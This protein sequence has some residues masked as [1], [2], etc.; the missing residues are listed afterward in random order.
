MPSDATPRTMKHVSFVQPAVASSETAR[1]I[2]RSIVLNF[3]RK[4]QPVSRAEV[5]RLSGLQRNT[6]SLI[7]E[8]LIAE[9]WVVEGAVGRLPR[10]RRPTFLELDG[11]RCAICVDLRPTRVQLGVGHLNGAFALSDQF[12]TP[13]TPERAT[14]ELVKRIRALIRSHPELTY[15]GIGITV[16]GRVDLQTQR[17]AFAPNLGWPPTDLKTPLERATGLTV[18]LE[19]AANACALA[20]LWFHPSDHP[21]DIIALTVSEGI[22][23]GIVSQGQLITGRSGMAGEFGHVSLDP[24]GLQCHCGNRGCWETLASERAGLRYYLQSARRAS[25]NIEFSDLL[26]MAE[27]GD[28]IAQRALNRMALE[29]A[30]GT[31]MMVAAIAPQVIVF[32]GEFTAAW[33]RFRPVI[34]AE[35]QSQSVG[36]PPSIVAGRDGGTARVRGTVAL[37]FHKHF[38]AGPPTR[39]CR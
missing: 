3:I 7:V 21:P 17:L 28:V 35:I 29:L 6:V 30:R 14:A 18:E 27:S 31:R 11:R 36:A 13:D 2:N 22:G 8:Q 4:Q 39:Y 1:Q 24:A 33:S 10:G 23:A 16:P 15:E 32:V 25:V 20:E 34:E 5:S 12:T 37:V 38:S 19:N 26:Q 9:Q